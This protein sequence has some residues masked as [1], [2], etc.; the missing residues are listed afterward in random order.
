MAGKNFTPSGLIVF[1]I[2]RFHPQMLQM[3]LDKPDE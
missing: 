3:T 1:A 2:F